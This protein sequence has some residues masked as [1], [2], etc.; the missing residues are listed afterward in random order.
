MSDTATPRTFTKGDSQGREWIIPQPVCTGCGKKPE[1]LAEYKDEGRRNKMSPSAF[2]VLM[3][4]TLN[5][6]NGHFLCT[7]CY[8]DAGCPSRPHPGRWVAP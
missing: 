7:P 2:V 3:E 1:E 8:C 6:A 4:G 5:Y